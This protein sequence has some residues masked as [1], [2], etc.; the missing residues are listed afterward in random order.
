MIPLLANGVEATPEPVVNSTFL[1]LII[2]IDL[3]GVSSV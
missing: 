2:F 1:D 3:V